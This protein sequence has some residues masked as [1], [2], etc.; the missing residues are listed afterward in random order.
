MVSSKIF[1]NEKVIRMSLQLFLV[2]KYHMSL[3]IRK[4]TCDDGDFTIPN[5]ANMRPHVEKIVNDRLQPYIETI[6]HTKTTVL[7][8]ETVIQQHL[9]MA[10]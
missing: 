1:G 5:F 8:Q 3:P 6:E 7:A 2:R 10:M 9:P 4:E